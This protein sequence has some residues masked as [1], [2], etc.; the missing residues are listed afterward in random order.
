MSKR[1]HIR[2][3]QDSDDEDNNQPADEDS[4]GPNSNDGSDN[5][6]ANISFRLLFFLYSF[7]SIE[8]Q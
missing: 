2:R 8:R 7:F 1:A 3:R 5:G 4:H 6:Y